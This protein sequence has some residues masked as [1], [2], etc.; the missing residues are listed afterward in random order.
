ADPTGDLVQTLEV[1]AGRRGNRA[2]RIVRSR[3]L[4]VSPDRI[5]NGSE[6]V[7]GFC[8]GMGP[9][10]GPQPAAAAG[11]ASEHGNV[12][13]SSLHKKRTSSEAAGCD[14]FRI[15]GAPPHEAMVA[16]HRPRGRRRLPGRP[17]P[18]GRSDY[19][20]RLAYTDRNFHGRSATLACQVKRPD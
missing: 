5:R 9:A 6:A 19:L 14:L 10:L 2:S 17:W 11:A 15:S 3:L 7:S 13:H 4:G 18:R 16:G 20:L 12:G 1:I 8:R